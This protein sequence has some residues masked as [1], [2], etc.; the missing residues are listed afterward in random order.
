M[1]EETK[2]KLRLAHAH[3]KRQE[4]S[5]QSKSRPATRKPIGVRV[6]PRQQE[7]GIEVEA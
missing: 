5:T 6:R 1:S 3:R 4:G 2:Q 7:D